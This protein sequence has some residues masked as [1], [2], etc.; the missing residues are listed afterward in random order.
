MKRGYVYRLE[1]PHREPMSIRGY[2]FGD[3][4]R[5]RS[6]AI[7][8]ATR[9]N[10][11]QQAYICAKLVARLTQLELAGALDPNKSILVVPCVNP[12]SMN[13]RSRFWPANGTDINRMFPGDEHGRTTERIAAGM[14][15][16]LRTYA[17]GIQLCSFHQPGDFLP[18]V[19][20]THQ[21]SLSDE[22]LQLAV[23]FGLPYV[24]HR[25]PTHIDTTTLNYAWQAEGTHAFSL[26]SRA[27]DRLDERSAREVEDATLRFLAA[28]GILRPADGEGC[29]D[30]AVGVA[31]GAPW[32][33]GTRDA[34]GAP[35]AA[36]TRNEA[37][38]RDAAGAGEEPGTPEARDAAGAGEEPGT[39][40]ARDAAG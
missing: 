28:R 25:K 26:Y 11:A 14:M 35:W 2:V 33:A 29:F 13:I 21:G 27:T 22:S 37:G 32:A 4:Q 36:G 3:E 39:P 18:H 23:D 20:V 12:Y 9:G 10:E 5:E 1:V 30:D 7:V 31:A 24:M 8:G 15:R 34:A 17:M 38:T 6:C 19:R 40:E 16:V